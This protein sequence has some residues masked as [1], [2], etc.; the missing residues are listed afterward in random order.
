MTRI[1]IDISSDREA[2]YRDAIVRI[3]DAEV[4][5]EGDHDALI[6]DR[7]EA[8]DGSLPVLLDA[9]EAC[10][11]GDLDSGRVMPAHPWR[12]FP[13]IA[14][15]HE[16]LMAGNLGVPGLLRTHYWTPNQEN[17]HSML[18]AQTDL[19]H[20]LF[21]ASPEIAHAITRPDYAQVHLGYPNGGMAMIDVAACRP[22]SDDYHSVHLI[23][24][25]GAAYSDDHRN[26][27]L[28]LRDGGTNALIHRRNALLATQ[29]MVVEFLGESWSLSLDDSK[30]ALATVREVTDA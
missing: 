1:R 26:T 9:P 21:D 15:L 25:D 11:L 22:G 5:G 30:E 19:A 8:I 28:V 16:Q 29:Q 3:P 18:F 6:T 24:S 10:K 27:H 13:N 7:P 2:L 17:L 14:P 4:V 20:W 23:G 12:F